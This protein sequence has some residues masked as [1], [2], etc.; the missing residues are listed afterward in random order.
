MSRRAL[1]ILLP[2]VVVVVFA[3]AWAAAA[4]FI[5]GAI[6][7]WA[8][9]QR[10][11]GVEVSWQTLEF[12]GFPVRLNGA[13][14]GARLAGDADGVTW[15]WTPPPLDLRFFPL[16]P[17]TVQVD[18]PGPHAIAVASPIN[19]ADLLAVAETATARVSAPR[20][21]NDILTTDLDIAGL[22]VA[23]QVTGLTAAARRVQL[24]TVA[25]TAS[26]LVVDTV[27]QILDL[28]LPADLGTLPLGD[29]VSAVAFNTTLTGDIPTS[30]TEDQIARWQ[31]SDGRL[32]INAVD[33]VWGPMNATGA[34]AVA[35][36]AALQPAGELTLSVS[37]LEATITAFEQAGMIDDNAAS[38]ARLV[39][40]ALARPGP[41]G[42]TVELPLT[43]VDRQVSLGPVPLLILPRIVWAP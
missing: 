13:M 2:V 14:A 37:G 33:V 7:T 38:L 4:R 8:A 16:S 29:T 3:G 36:D 24:S 32:T 27:G 23:D 43:I 20:D 17:R 41:N 28:E 34:G 6:D 42:N 22:T 12:D 31:A 18:A 10:R 9:E 40:L 25:A 39:L 1:V 30:P 19:S 11:H 5:A 15:S 21:I 35:L 26:P